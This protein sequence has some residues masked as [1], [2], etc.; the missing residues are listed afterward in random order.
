MESGKESNK[1]TD[2]RLV[3][4]DTQAEQYYNELYNDLPTEV[5]Q[6]LVDT[7]PLAGREQ[8]DPEAFAYRTKKRAPQELEQIKAQRI[9]SIKNEDIEED[10]KDVEE[11]IKDK[12]NSKN[13]SNI[14]Q[15]NT[16]ELKKSSKNYKNLGNIDEELNS[17]KN[18]ESDVIKIAKRLEKPI[19]KPKKYNGEQ[20]EPLKNK[21]SQKIYNIEDINKIDELEYSSNIFEKIMQAGSNVSENDDTKE[22]IKSRKKSENNKKIYEDTIHK[23]TKRTVSKDYNNIDLDK[24]DKQINLDTL[25]D[26]K[27]FDD[28]EENFFQTLKGKFALSALCVAGV[29]IIFLL[30]FRVATLSGNL[31]EAKGKIDDYVEMEQRYEETKL[32][33]LTLESELEKYKDKEN[34]SNIE[35]QPEVVPEVQQEPQF[36]QTLN[37]DMVSPVYNIA[38]N[39]KV[40]MMP[41]AGTYTTVAGDTYTIISMKVYGNYSGYRKIMAANGVTDEN[42]P[43]SIGKVLKIPK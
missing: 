35:N 6:M 15:K 42:E 30:A 10:V 43:V 23:P 38:E 1:T 13:N 18:S 31:D 39:A 24:L 14:A 7:H 25:Y 22:K 2:R 3:M 11:D 34:I 21:N 26:D 33:K 32:E 40:A 5:A 8:D 20:K 36:A 4:K 19:K 29:L 9:N 28:E 17:D 16:H 37:F 41:L 27:F 12:V